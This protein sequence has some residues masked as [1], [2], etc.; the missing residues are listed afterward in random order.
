MTARADVYGKYSLGSGAILSDPNR[1]WNAL[2]DPQVVADYENSI[3][4]DL[5]KSGIPIASLFDWDIMDVGT[6]RQAL[7]FLSM[8]ARHVVHHDISAE[9][10]ARVE[11]HIQEAAL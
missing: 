6:G 7:A 4:R 8:G 11:A 9:N 3:R 5:A 1:V 10:V 2:A